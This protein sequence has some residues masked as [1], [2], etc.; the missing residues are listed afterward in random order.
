MWI[1]SEPTTSI[2]KVT[3]KLDTA[4]IIKLYQ[5]QAKG[6][7]RPWEILEMSNSIGKLEWVFPI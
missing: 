4:R 1:T 6:D 2:K 3:F 7:I 5:G